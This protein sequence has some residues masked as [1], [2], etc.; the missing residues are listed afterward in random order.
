MTVPT[1]CSLFPAEPWPTAKR[2]AERRYTDL[3]SWRALDRG[4]HFPGLEHP[5]VLV[6]EVRAA[7]RG[8]R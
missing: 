6:E 5:D 4:G 3:R 2:W 8:L 1:A 7:F